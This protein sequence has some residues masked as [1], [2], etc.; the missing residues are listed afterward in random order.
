LVV[1]AGEMLELGPEEVKLHKETGREMTARGI[2]VLW[3]IRGL[4]KEMAAGA[5]E[6][7][8]ADVR[9][10][11]SSA[12]AAEAI[13]TGVK[14]GDLILVKGSRG[15]ATDKVVKALREHFPLIGEDM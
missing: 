8:L 11:D 1:I 3:G 4:A 10:F 6:A 14:A 12:E 15:V 7:G 2:N 13:V 5:A 9:F